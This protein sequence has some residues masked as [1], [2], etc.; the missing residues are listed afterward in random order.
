MLGQSTAQRS[1]FC[2]VETNQTA[3]Q[4]ELTNHAGRTT[5]VRPASLLST[6]EPNFASLTD[7]TPDDRTAMQDGRISALAA[8]LAPLALRGEPAS[9]PSDEQLAVAMATLR[10]LVFPA[11][12]S[13]AVALA[14]NSP[15]DDA[16][17]GPELARRFA[18]LFDDLARDAYRASKLPF[19]PSA[20]ERFFSL[21]PSIAARLESDVRAAYRG[22][23]AAQNEL[24]III[25]Y[26]GV[27]ALFVH[28]FAHALDALGVP[29]LPRMMSEFAHR[30]T[31]IDIH[32]AA[33]IG[34]ELF[35]DH[36]TG[37]V[38]GQTAVIGD[39]CRIY[40]GVTLGAKNFEREPDGSL[41]RGYRR[42]PTLED[43]VTVYAGATI[44]GGDTVIGRG[45]VVAGGVFLT[46]S[47]PAGHLVT[48]PKLQLRVLSIEDGI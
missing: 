29:L 20:V 42:H 31:G 36:G 47:V 12:R 3:V 28:R 35:I 27:R 5:H 22:D 17:S 8:S 40:Q 18:E 6:F 45:S 25:C 46:K 34:D 19:D 15:T 24:E 16:P 32:P 48:G 41:R 14:D 9:P 44:L 7:F 23:P 4:D 38:I 11:L 37:V 43:D 10:R 33:R 26:P 21:I 30:E 1:S 39:R 13:H 2:S